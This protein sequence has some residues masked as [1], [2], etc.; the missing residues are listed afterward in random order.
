MLTAQ[1]Q[2]SSGDSATADS[3]DSADEGR[4]CSPRFGAVRRVISVA[5]FAALDAV[6]LAALAVNHRCVFAS[7]L[8][9]TSRYFHLGVKP[10]LAA[11]AYPSWWRVN[12]ITPL[13]PM[14][15]LMR[16]FVGEWRW[17]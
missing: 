3:G 5:P 14:R 13:T 1:N 6:L 7:E 17:G 8:I 2:F 16:H 10:L 9:A 4:P 15:L 12:K 11:A